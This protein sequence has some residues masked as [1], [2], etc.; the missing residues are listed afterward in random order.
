V[1]E[2]ITTSLLSPEL[3]ENKVLEVTSETTAP[4]QTYEELLASIASDVSRDQQ[5]ASREAAAAARAQV[6][7]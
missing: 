6:T 3:A 7:L 2:L 4:K 5:A 1:A